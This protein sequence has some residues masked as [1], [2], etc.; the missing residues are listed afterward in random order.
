MSVADYRGTRPHLME[1]IDPELVPGIAGSLTAGLPDG[2]I[3][4]EQVRA[5]DDRLAGWVALHD[6]E[7]ERA[8]RPD[9]TELELRLHRSGSD[10]AVLWLHG[11]GMFLGAAW[12]EDE[13][14]RALAAAVGNTVVVPDYRLA[15]EHPYPAP[16]DD[17]LRALRWTAERFAR[18]VVAGASAGGGLAAGLA[19]RAR[20]AGGPTIAALHLYH[21]MLDDRGTTA[22]ARA[23]ADAV[24]WNERLNALGW[25]AYLGGQPADEYAAPAR[26]TELRGLPPAYIDT[27]ELDM[28]R[29]EDVDFALRLAAAEVPVELHLERGAVHAFDIIAPE[30]QVSRAT[31][32]RRIAALRRDLGGLS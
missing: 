13:R 17:C 16:L 20:D 27:G 21:P 4:V 28:F 19:L 12:C 3:T 6:T 7:V 26:A 23:F 24:V 18:V 22:S 30:A 32:T 25:T 11:G 9:G 8:A 15:P 29:D 31:R 1:R 14:S 2:A 10:A 5:L